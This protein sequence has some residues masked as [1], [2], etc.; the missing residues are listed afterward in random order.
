M[1]DNYWQNF[2]LMF[3]KVAPRLQISETKNILRSFEFA[4]L[5]ASFWKK[6]N[7]QNL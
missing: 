5:I 3:Y 2:L 1:W 7:Q 4:S 6:K